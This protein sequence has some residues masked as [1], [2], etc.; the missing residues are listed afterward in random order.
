MSK[1]TI[2]SSTRQASQ[3]HVKPSGER[4]GQRASRV[5]ERYRT[6]TGSLVS[7]L[8]SDVISAQQALTSTLSGVVSNIVSLVLPLAAMLWLSWPVTV[9]AVALI[10]LFLIPARFN[11]AGA[12]L[13]K[14][15]GRPGSD[16]LPTASCTVIFM[17]R[18]CA[19]ACSRRPGPAGRHCPARPRRRD[20]GTDAEQDTL[21]YPDLAH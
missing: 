6:Q 15:F 20:P 1:Q 11:V 5:F 19:H 16:Q 2:W 8:N 10:P 3:H 12:M 4:A 21:R 17:R 18:F 13:V 7:R 9:A 14:L